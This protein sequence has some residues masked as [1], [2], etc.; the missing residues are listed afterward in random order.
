MTIVIDGVVQNSLSPLS[1]GGR[2]IDLTLESTDAGALGAS[3]AALSATSATH[4]SQIGVLQ[5]SDSTQSGQITTLQTT[6]G[7]HTTQISS[8]QAS[9]TTQNGQITTL[10]T[11]T[12]THTTQIANLQPKSFTLALRPA[13]NTFSS[14][15]VIL[16]TTTNQLNTANGSIWYDPNGNIA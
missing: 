3:V 12:G 15:Q 2:L 11:T 13:A 14:G 6:T 16:N 7:T 10:Q 9:D 1:P 5:T 4:T 8:L